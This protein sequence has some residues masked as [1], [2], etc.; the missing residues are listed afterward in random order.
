MMNTSIQPG[1]IDTLIFFCGTVPWLPEAIR[2]ARQQGVKTYV[3]GVTRH[4]DELFDVPSKPNPRTF[5]MVLE[6]ERI[7]YFHV[8]DINTSPELVSVVTDKTMG[9]GIGEAYTF[10]TETLEL[11]KRRLYDFMIIRLPQYRGGAHSTWEILRGGR[12]GGWNVQQVNEEMIPGGFDSGEILKTR[13]Y[14][15]PASAKIPQDYF[16]VANKEG[17]ALFKEFLDEVQ[18]G[19]EFALA[20]V[21]ENFASYFPRL[22]TLKHGWIDWSWTVQEIER[23][24]CAFDEPYT[25]ASTYLHGKRVHLKSCQSDTLDGTFHPFMVGLVYRTFG[26]KVF[27]AVKDGS[28]IAERIVDEQGVDI[29][30]TIR[31]GQRL[32]TPQAELESAMMFSAEYNTEGLKTV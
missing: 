27:I 10:T 19:K 17:L 16:E 15:I 13:E 12:I 18:S 11:F 1:P 23:F 21:Q 9:L 22:Y 6:E 29:T 31:V 28:I 20:K 7:P 2:L 4:L 3:F 30:A 8:A 14:L 24:I 26:G 5:R 32:Y 25:G